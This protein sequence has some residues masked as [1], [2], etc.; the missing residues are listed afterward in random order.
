MP[1]RPKPPTSLRSSVRASGVQ[2]PGARV[3]SPRAE[4]RHQGAAPDANKP[5]KPHCTSARCLRASFDERGGV[6]T[7]LKTARGIGC[8]AAAAR[9]WG[10]TGDDEPA[11]RARSRASRRAHR[12]R[13]QAAA[14]PAAHG[15]GRAAPRTR[16]RVGVAASTRRS[17]RLA[18]RVQTKRARCSVAAG[19]GNGGSGGGGRGERREGVGLGGGGG[20]AERG[21]R[22]HTVMLSSRP[23]SASATDLTSLLT[24]RMAMPRRAAVADCD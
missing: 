11:G 2:E 15:L 18:P 1:Q 20:H 8:S 4:P 13:L 17:G 3:T 5:D 14:R 7:A 6:A 12:A 24:A 16:A 19:E 23:S 21:S 22:S 10:R 9:A